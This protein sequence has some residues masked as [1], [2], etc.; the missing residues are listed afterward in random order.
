[1][2]SRWSARTPAVPENIYITRSV[3]HLMQEE[4]RR[5]TATGLGENETGGILIGRRLD[6]LEVVELL[7]T[8]A[9]GPGDDAL[10]HSIEFNF[11]VEYVNQKLDEYRADYPALDY[12]G[13]WHKHPLDYPSFSQGDV[14]TAHQLFQDPTYKIQEI[15][16]P[17]VWIEDDSFTIRYYYMHRKMANQGQPF[18][19]IP[20][21]AVQVIDDDDALVVYEQALESR[22]SEENRRLIDRG[23]RLTLNKEDHDYIFTV[24]VEH[25]PD[26]AIY[27]IAHND[28]P[29]TPPDVIVEQGG[30]EIE[31][32]DGNIISHWSEHGGRCYLVEIV[33]NEVR[34][35]IEQSG[36][37]PPP[38]T[39]TSSQSADTS[40]TATRNT[41]TSPT[42][43]SSA[44]GQMLAE[45][46]D[47]PAQ[48][49]N[50][51]PLVVTGVAV[52]VVLLI[53]LFA[54][55]TETGT[56]VAGSDPSRST[57]G[58]AV[59]GVNATAPTGITI[60]GMGGMVQ[61]GHSFTATVEMEN[62]TTPIT[63]TWQVRGQSDRIN[64]ADGLTNTATLTWDTPGSY[65]ITVTAT[66]SAGM[67]TDTHRVTIVR[68][69]E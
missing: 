5:H 16:N 20:A 33:D 31:G 51:L 44:T 29:Q 22:M 9:T 52:V 35:L 66:N 45:V 64:A 47:A 4:A 15:I 8:A 24:N 67:V 65:A 41:N 18:V 62:T 23:Y 19:E 59:V 50:R 40:D 17:I 58:S 27:L 21:Q 26:V 42:A 34:H 25:L 30:H 56:P 60:H 38:T 46:P 11:D 36:D 32:N 1:M 10:H 54:T 61:Q 55:R 13:T 12:I 2:T 39:P 49:H 43:S 14:D 53:I 63:Y 68:G 6:G 69:D 28:Y 57:D 37:S 3:L 7:I 48:S